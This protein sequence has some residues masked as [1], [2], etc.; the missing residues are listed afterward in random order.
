MHSTSSRSRRWRE[1]FTAAIAATGVVS[2]LA[3]MI[4]MGT[5]TSVQANGQSGDRGKDEVTICHRGSDA[6]AKWTPISVDKTSIDSPSGHA[7]TDPYDI[8][9]PFDDFLGLNWDAEGLLIYQQD[10][11][12]EVDAPEEP[13]VVAATCELPGSFSLPADTVALDWSINP[14]YEGPGD[15]TVSVTAIP[16]FEFKKPKSGTLSWQIF[17]P[18]QLTGPACDGADPTPQ[19]IE[20]PPKPTADAPTCTAAGQFTVPADTDE[21]DWSELGREATEAGYTVTVGVV[22]Q[23]GF[24]FGDDKPSQEFEIEVLKQLDA[25]DPACDSGDST[26]P[27]TW[28]TTAG[29][30]DCETRTF[31]TVT[32]SWSQQSKEAT[33]VVDG[34]QESS[35]AATASELADAGCSQPGGGNPPVVV[36][37]VEPPTKPTRPAALVSIDEQVEVDCDADEVVTTTTTT[38]TDWVFNENAWAWVKDTPAAVVVTETTPA[39]DGECP[40]VVLPVEG[41]EPAP[42]VPDEGGDKPVTQPD[43]N[44]GEVEGVDADRPKPRPQPVVAGQP[45]ALPTAVDAGLAPVVA[46]STSSP[47]GQGL[48]AG[49]LV[50]LL[51]AGALQTG[52]RERGTHEI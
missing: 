28:Q 47:L 45:E 19:L 14:A 11:S 31:I 51:L 18:S 17:V 39:D 15:Y 24:T 52:R 4:V 32:T 20:V 26:Y 1:R 5:A 36:P 8:I 7:K 13:P 9:P 16:P 41:E 40:D 50:M 21:L 12:A 23:D 48:L 6:N 34:T 2:L 46:T 30:V 43:K 22:P 42:V 27:R 35:R 33:A 44:D 37:P 10:C 3:G 38:T 49:G 29:Q 25:D